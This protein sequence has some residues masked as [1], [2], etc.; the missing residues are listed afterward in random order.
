MRPRTD[1]NELEKYHEGLIVCSACLRG[2]CLKDNARSVDEAEEANSMVQEPF[3]EDADLS[4]NAI[5]AT[6]LGTVPIMKR[7]H[8]R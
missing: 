7:I 4:F 5:K 3:G 6:V 8:C 1:R 2:R